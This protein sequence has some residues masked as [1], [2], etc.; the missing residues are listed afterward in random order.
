MS[1]KG[2]GLAAIQLAR[3]IGAKNVYVTAGSDAKIEYC[4]KMGATAGVNYKAQDWAEEVSS[5][6]LSVV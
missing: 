3:Q 5:L 1:S 2:V 6:Q 4:K